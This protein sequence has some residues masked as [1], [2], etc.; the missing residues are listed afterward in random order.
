MTRRL[1]WAAI[2]VALPL[3]AS[4]TISQTRVEAQQ[5]PRPASPAQSS[6]GLQLDALDRSG[7]A[8]TDFYQFAC[9]GW[10]A[11]NPVPA[12]RASWGRF[13]ELQERNNETLHRILE[14]AAAGK[15]PSSKKIGDYYASCLDE[16]A[17]DAKGAAPLDPLLTKIAAL[18]SL[19]DLAPLVAELHTIGV[20]VFFQF[21]SQ[22]DFKDA[23]VEMA[24]VDQGGL[25]LPDRDYYLNQDQKSTDLRRQYV[26][27]LSKTF[28]LLGESSDQAA[29]DAK[30]VMDL[31]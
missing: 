21:G 17:I 27:H 29:A 28:V 24:I 22:A 23:S 11:K 30:V 25:G 1:V 31:E 12:D 5:P 7:D 8:C 18:S 3:A 14:A 15:D 26:G 4:L 19:N 9:G 13:E 10:I 6:S 16:T 20:N 2:F